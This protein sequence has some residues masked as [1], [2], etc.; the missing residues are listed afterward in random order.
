MVN[1]T[2]QCGTN[3]SIVGFIGL[4]LPDNNLTLC[5]DS[6]NDAQALLQSQ[7]CDQPIQCE[8]PSN[9]TETLGDCFYK[10]A[11][12]W[13][14]VVLMSIGTIGFNVANCVSDATCF[15]VLGE[16]TMN[17]GA[18]RVYGTI[19]FGVTALISASKNLAIYSSKLIR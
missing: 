13:S 9:A 11:T 3:S 17:Y 7:T 19:G 8:M 6:A 5:V 1:C 2:I 12:F 14:F 18:Q 4:S 16:K 10:T 15:D